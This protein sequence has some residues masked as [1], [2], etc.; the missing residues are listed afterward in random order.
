MS[1]TTRVGE[2]QIEKKVSLGTLGALGV[3]AIVVIVFLVQ[4]SGN[5]DKNTTELVKHD[6]R[7]STVEADVRKY[8]NLV[9]R[10]TVVE[11]TNAAVTQK[12]DDLQQAVNTQSGDIRVMREIL[13]RLESQSKAAVFDLGRTPALARASA[14]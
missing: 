2:W 12:L 9:Y 14:E 4:M 10:I 1:T 5:V 6:A 7:I 13:Q 11:Q 8:D 3:Q